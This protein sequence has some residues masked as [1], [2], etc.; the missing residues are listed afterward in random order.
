MSF[1]T[2][3]RSVGFCGFEMENLIPPLGYRRRYPTKI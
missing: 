1:K 3:N 2:M